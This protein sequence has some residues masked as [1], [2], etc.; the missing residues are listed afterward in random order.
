[1]KVKKLHELLKSA[2]PNAT[3]VLCTDLS[4][5]SSVRKLGK[6][7]CKLVLLRE[8]RRTVREPCFVLWP[9]S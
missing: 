1:M 8:P 2:D 6:V 5:R 4:P 9:E 3:V 7:G